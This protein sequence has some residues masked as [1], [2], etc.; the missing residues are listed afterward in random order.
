[1]IIFGLRKI[2]YKDPSFNETWGLSLMYNIPID[3]S[4]EIEKTLLIDPI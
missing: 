1:M 3:S 2:F 4:R